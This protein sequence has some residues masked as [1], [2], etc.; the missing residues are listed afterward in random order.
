MDIV[1]SSKLQAALITFGFLAI[2]VIGWADYRTWMEMSFSIFYL[3]PIIIITW[4]SNIWTGISASL[5][6]AITWSAADRMGGHVHSYE[7]IPYWNA[8]VRFGFYIIITII[9]SR[10]KQSMDNTVQLY[11]KLEASYNELKQAEIALEQKAL[12]LSRSNADLEQFAYAAAHDLKAPLITIGGYIN[13]LR[14][15]YGEKLD[16]N[17]HE[18]IDTALQGVRRMERL[19]GGLLSYARVESRGKDVGP[20][21]MD[22]VVRTALSHLKDATHESRATITC[23][24]LFTVMADDVQMAQLFQ[25]LIGNALKFRGTE[26]PRIDIFAEHNDGEWILGIR[27]NGIGIA[28]GHLERIFGIFERVAGEGEYEGTG[29]GLAICRKIVERHGGRIWVES[30]V[31]RGSTFY[32]TLPDMMQSEEPGK[33]PGI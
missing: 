22:E 33:M 20:T 16:K 26:V 3:V 24:P 19:I 1:R 4:A 6:S 2:F 15:D 31:G 28:A 25:N 17:A 30:E 10:L 11:R 23:A 5:L 18:L 14:K 21:N 9:L 7:W 13:L 12:E 27:D 8:F 32:F 29:I